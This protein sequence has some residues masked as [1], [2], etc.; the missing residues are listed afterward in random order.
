MQRPL[1]GYNTLHNTLVV[2]V[3]HITN[4]LKYTMLIKILIL[5]WLLHVSAVCGHPQVVY[6]I[7]EH[8]T[9]YRNDGSSTRK[10][11]K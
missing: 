1:I 11:R 7:V 3:Y 8:V 5:K 2:Y 6:K 9:H 4:Q 10:I